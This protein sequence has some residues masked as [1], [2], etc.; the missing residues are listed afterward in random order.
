MELVLF[1]VLL[2][3]IITISYVI[4]CSV[5]FGF[6]ARPISLAFKLSWKLALGTIVGAPLFGF[7]SL[8]IPAI[9]FNAAVE[10]LANYSKWRDIAVAIIF[11]AMCTAEMYFVVLALAWDVIG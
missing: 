11:A 3:A 9:W 6:T 4:L 7:G 2:I 8:L 10:P 1:F 5:Y